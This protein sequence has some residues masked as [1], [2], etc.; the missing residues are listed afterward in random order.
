MLHITEAVKQLRGGA[1]EPERQVPN[2]R[3]GIVSGHGGGLSCHA[4]LIFSNEAA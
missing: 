2:A 1:I 3:L 4:T